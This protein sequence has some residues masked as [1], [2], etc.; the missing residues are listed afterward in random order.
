MPTVVYVLALGLF[1]QLWSDT[2]SMWWWRWPMYKGSVVGLWLAVATVGLVM[3]KV[4]YYK[5]DN[6]AE[7][8]LTQIGLA[9]SV[10][11][12]LG[13]SL[14]ADEELDVVN[15]SA[16]LKTTLEQAYGLP[17]ASARAY[18]GSTAN[19]VVE[20]APGCYVKVEVRGNTPAEI[21]L[22]FTETTGIVH[23]YRPADAGQMTKLCDD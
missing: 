12:A 17:V 7:V 2:L 16:R 18:D 19:A 22:V 15:R 20:V 9:L 3:T 8:L 21:S 1:A 6:S 23:A 5:H 10:V 13:I 11:L 4:L 14:I